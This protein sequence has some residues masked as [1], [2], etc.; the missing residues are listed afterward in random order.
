M[1]QN[2]K[3]RWVPQ[4]SIHHCYK[5]QKIH[6]KNARK[7][8]QRCLVP[9]PLFTT[10]RGWQR[11]SSTRLTHMEKLLRGWHFLSTHLLWTGSIP[12]QNISDFKNRNNNNF[13]A[14]V[15]QVNNVTAIQQYPLSGFSRSRRLCTCSKTLTIEQDT[16][17]LPS[18]E[19]PNYWTKT[20]YCKLIQ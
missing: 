2:V 14:L 13:T 17:A 1:L 4:I 12:V 8:K 16:G 18:T 6:T 5:I 11:D 9:F 20:N 10:S 15:G 7:L 3:F 19:N